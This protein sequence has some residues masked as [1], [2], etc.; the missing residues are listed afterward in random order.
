MNLKSLTGVRNLL[1]VMAV[2]LGFTG[3]IK[4]GPTVC[5]TE[6]SL[7]ISIKANADGAVQ[8]PDKATI[9]LFDQQR[10]SL[11][12]IEVDAETIASG[13][14]VR[15]PFKA[16]G[17]PWVVVWANLS[18]NEVITPIE[19]GITLDQMTV[20]LGKD[21]DGYDLQP[22]DLFYGIKQLTGKTVEVI[23]IAPKTAKINLTV[24]GLPWGVVAEDYYFTVES[25]YGKYDFT[26][27]PHKDM[28]THLLKGQFTDSHDLVTPLSYNLIH[29]PVPDLRYIMMDTATVNLWKK[30]TG[31]AGDD[32]L[33][34]VNK[35]MNGQ[36]LMP[37]P[38]KTMNIL[39]H[40]TD[41]GNIEVSVVITD[42]NEIYQWN[43]W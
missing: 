13:E 1:M 23:D 18:N 35:D 29:Y 22:D 39:I 17:K 33:A 11:E 10:V 2:A 3:C 27:L 30:T 26:G 15:I 32:L 42:W 7:Y 24:K 16:E 41:T 36:P 34:T 25:H 40:F 4:E 5:P 28:S 19:P 6:I 12:R 20:G 43:E 37:Q 38:G 31:A 21:A 14:P 8:I 9:F